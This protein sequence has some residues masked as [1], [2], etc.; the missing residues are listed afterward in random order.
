M[1]NFTT[2]ILFL[3]SFA[4]ISGVLASKNT[5]LSHSRIFYSNSPLGNR[6]V[7]FTTNLYNT[8]GLP[9]S[10]GDGNVVVFD[11]AYSDNVDGNDATKLTDPGV[12]FGL[13]RDGIALAIEARQPI[14]NTDTIFYDMW[15]MRQQ[16]YQ[17]EF[18]PENMD[19]ADMAAYLIDNY[20]NTSTALS[21]SGTSDV[22]FTVTSD[23]GSSEANR[24]EVIFI[25]SSNPLPVTFTGISATLQ[26]DAAIAVNWK[27][28]SETD[29][30]QYNVERS[31]D[32]LNF[33]QQTTV[34][35]K[36]NNG[37]ATTYNW[38]DTDPAAGM[39]YY[40]IKSLSKSG[41]V[42]YSGI[43]KE[44]IENAKPGISVYPNPVASG[45]VNLMLSNL[46]SGPYKIRVLNMSG[47]E[48]YAT[49]IN[50]TAGATGEKLNIQ[51]ILSMGSYK[52]EAVAAN[53]KVYTTGI[54]IK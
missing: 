14:Q 8:P 20:L 32:G 28:V 53:D 3:C 25:N 2:V 1:K 41:T 7:K 18:I 54:F 21:L 44:A 31:T 38:V 35:A 29:V 34:A 42:T 13:E 30:Q 51:G 5:R 16:Q 46:S 52:L 11:S 36:A 47:Q 9:S 27:V 17:M 15:H 45:Q 43:A 12:N 39:D 19:N 26:S 4:P 40:R 49:S 48:V 33:S 10:L 37:T 23:P 50:H 24:F 6:L 22:T